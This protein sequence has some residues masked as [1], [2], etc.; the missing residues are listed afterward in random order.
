MDNYRFSSDDDEAGRDSY[1]DDAQT[2][3]I[4]R[5]ARKVSLAR[6]ETAPPPRDAR[7]GHIAQ[8][9]QSLPPAWR[10]PTELLPYDRIEGARMQ[11]ELRLVG[12]SHVEVERRAGTGGKETVV[13]RMPA[14]TTLFQLAQVIDERHLRHVRPLDHGVLGRKWSFALARLD[15]LEGAAGHFGSPFG[16]QF[17]SPFGSRRSSVEG[18]SNTY[19][20]FGPEP[21]F[22]SQSRF[23]P[24]TRESAT[25]LFRL[26]LQAGEVAEFV[27][28]VDALGG[29]A[30]HVRINVRAVI[31]TDPEEDEGAWVINFG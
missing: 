18:V 13:V 21:S 27:Y 26:G 5:F 31:C 20:F 9:Q 15:P 23:P 6:M 19:R 3:L 14:T 4:A 25:E 24:Q 7:A 17:V 2:E 30:E 10:G 22:A 29:P 8:L 16:S 12:R 11:Y 28:D 1:M